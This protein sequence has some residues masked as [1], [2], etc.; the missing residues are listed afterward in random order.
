MRDSNNN[1][2]ARAFIHYYIVRESLK[3]KTFC[4]SVACLTRHSRQR[5]NIILEKVKSGVDGR[6]EFQSQTGTFVFIPGSR[7]N[8]LRGCFF[9][10]P[11]AAH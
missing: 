9:E 2:F 1:K 8:R 4:S 3:D 10:Y 5:N 7:F 11:Y 6:A